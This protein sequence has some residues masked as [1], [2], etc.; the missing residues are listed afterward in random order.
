MYKNISCLFDV[1]KNN[2]NNISPHHF[3]RCCHRWWY[4]C[5]Q[6]LC[7]RCVRLHQRPESFRLYKRFVQTLHSNRRELVERSSRLLVRGRYLWKE[8]RTL[9]RKIEK[10]FEPP[11]TRI[12]CGHDTYPPTTNHLPTTQPPTLTDPYTR[13]LHKHPRKF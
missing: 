2:N 13:P 8:S 1:Y 4:I 10:K 7:T 5:T 9:I 11:C 12:I 6:S 3:G